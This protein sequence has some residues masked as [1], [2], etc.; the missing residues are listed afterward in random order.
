MGLDLAPLTP[1]LRGIL[2]ACGNDLP[3]RP[4]VHERRLA[5]AAAKML[6]S[7]SPQSLFPAARSPQG[8]LAGLWLRA[9]GWEEAHNASQD[10]HTPDGSYWH[11]IVHRQEPDAGNAGYWFRRVGE[12]PIFPALAN[13]A[14]AE[15]E[16]HS[17][18]S[19]AAAGH[20]DPFGFVDYCEA[21]RRKIGS[22]NE[23][24]ARAIQEIEWWLLFD[25]CA[26]P[27]GV[28]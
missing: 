26:R 7:A 22:P 6:A 23:L 8:A 25:S 11:G 3:L 24:L 20:W 2:D 13:A 10:L 4:L 18:A 9:G 12:H 16:R 21:A 17:S 1:A 27:G 19:W 14:A 15:A 28:R 5:P